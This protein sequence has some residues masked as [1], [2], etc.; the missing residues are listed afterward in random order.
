MN[1]Y[2]FDAN[3]LIHLFD[4]YYESRFPTLWERFNNSV[5][6]G[7]IISVREVKNEIDGYYKKD[8]KINQW[9][10]KKSKIFSIPTDEEMLF[11][12]EIF[13]IERFQEGV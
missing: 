5:D 9:A 8:R 3:V 6:I 2:V 7:Q 4:Y 13:K 12:Q 11:V 1:I 10:R